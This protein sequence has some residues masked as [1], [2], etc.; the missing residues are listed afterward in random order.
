MGPCDNLPSLGMWCVCSA[1]VRVRYEPRK[2]TLYDRLF[3]GQGTGL[4]LC[5]AGGTGCM[6]DC[7]VDEVGSKTGRGRGRGR[8]MSP[9]PDFRDWQAGGREYAEGGIRGWFSVTSTT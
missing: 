6:C 3:C 2:A 9:N 1:T 7:R 4:E 5:E 8:L